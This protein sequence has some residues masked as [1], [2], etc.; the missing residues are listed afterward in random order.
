MVGL[1]VSE[2]L[3]MFD[4]V[5]LDS[6][7]P[8]HI[9]GHGS[10]DIFLWFGGWVAVPQRLRLPDND[11]NLNSDVV[12]LLLSSNAVGGLWMGV[13]PLLPPLRGTLLT[14]SVVS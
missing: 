10:E 7:E 9:Y 4:S 2:E 8:V 5:R 1:H 3:V 14:T 11:I 13:V 6:A 12:S